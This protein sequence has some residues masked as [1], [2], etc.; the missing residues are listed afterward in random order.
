MA[1]NLKVMALNLKVEVKNVG[2]MS[3][4]LTFKECLKLV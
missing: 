2:L 3:L 1:L 4:M